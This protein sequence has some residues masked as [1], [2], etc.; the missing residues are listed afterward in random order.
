[1]YF[2]RLLWT[3]LGIVILPFS[4]KAQLLN[5]D[6]VL[7]H[8]NSGATL[9]VKGDVKTQNNAG[10]DLLGVFNFTG[11]LN[12]QG[13][14]G[15]FTGTGTVELSGNGQSI[16]GTQP[17][18]FP[19]LKVTVAGA[20]TLHRSISVGGSNAAGILDLQLG[21]IELSGHDLYLSNRNATAITYSSGNI[22]AEG[23]DFVGSVYWVIGNVTGKHTVP[24]VNNAGWMIP[25]SITPFTGN[26][27]TV[28]LSTYATN[29]ANL[30]LPT[31]P[32]NVTHIRNTSGANNSANT[33][34]RFW[35]A[36]WNTSGVSAQL[37]FE[38]DPVESPANGNVSPRAQRWNLL[39]D[40]WDVPLPGQFNLTPHEVAVPNVTVPGTWAIAANNNP[41]PITL[42]SFTARA[43]QNSR[44][45]LDWTTLTEVENDYFTIERS[46]DG[47]TFEK[48]IRTD[49]AGT[50]YL[51]NSYSEVDQKPYVG[52]SYYRLRQTDFNGTS[53]FTTPVAVYL[54]ENG[55]THI[56]V[57]PNPASDILSIQVDG[58]EDAQDAV[59]ELFSAAGERVF[60]TR[61]SAL[62]SNEFGSFI[63]PIAAFA[64]GAYHYRIM[65]ESSIIGTGKIIL[66]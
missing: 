56:G 43:E 10:V 45:K 40:G 34:D 64:R 24:F 28:R 14:P 36:R 25:V 18:D 31:V 65:T 39:H 12:N 38:Y 3:L 29:A 50:S 22:L 61:L 5:A 8:I 53:T 2:A 9:F 49:G 51:P 4:L 41:L 11:D 33:V 35:L 30:P 54:T 55:Y 63:L 27:D 21:T 19:S 17:L 66:K 48:I 52:K 23:V 16:G 47:L 1:M 7:I 58:A 6:N 59:L 44:V 60:H 57:Y 37:N 32:E 15:G 46:V 26:L 20:K 13:L 42:L 62:S